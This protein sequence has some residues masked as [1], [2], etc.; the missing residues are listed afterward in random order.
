MKTLLNRPLHISRYVTWGDRRH[1]ELTL[2]RLAVSRWCAGAPC[3]HRG[4]EP[5]RH[6]LG[7]RVWHRSGWLR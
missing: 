4:A 1:W 6:P 2:G 7:A 5:G 3:G